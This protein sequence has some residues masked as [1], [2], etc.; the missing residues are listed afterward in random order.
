MAVSFPNLAAIFEHGYDTIIDV[1]SPDEFAEDHVPGAINLPV[2]SNEERAVVGTIYVQDSPF[3]ARKVGA[4]LVAKNAAD[5]IA[6][7][8]ADHDGGWKPLVYCWRGGQRSGSFTGILQQIG[9]RADV[10]DG[11]YQ[12]YRKLVHAALYSNP[13]AHRFILLDGNTGSAK[14]ALLARLQD[15][16]IQVIDLEGLANHRGSL[17]GEMPGG[18]PHQKGFESALAAALAAADPRRPIVV[19]A[20]SSKIGQIVLPPQLWSRMKEAPRIEISAPIEARTAFLLDAYAEATEQAD[21]DPTALTAKLDLLRHRR[22]NTIVETWLEHLKS[23]DMA[24]LATA[25]MTDHYDPAYA[26]SRKRGADKIRHVVKA[27][28]LDTAGQERAAD[29]IAELIK[30]MSV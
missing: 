3:K 27:R 8:L 4:A 15:R 12:S 29:E 5:H 21:Q 2:L 6:G 26:Q 10:V 17:L 9:W 11:G 19:E 16:G 20:E 18:Q 25:L 13:L 7:P 1:R 22:G 24:A 30:T 28:S 23:G 14:T